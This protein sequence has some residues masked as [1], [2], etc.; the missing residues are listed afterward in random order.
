MHKLSG[1]GHA[2]RTL[3]AASSSINICFDPP[4]QC[5]VEAQHARACPTELIGPLIRVGLGSSIVAF[6][7][8]RLR[9][10]STTKRYRS[11]QAMLPLHFIKHKVRLSVA[12][13]GILWAQGSKYNIQFRRLRRLVVCCHC[14]F[15]FAYM[16]Q[17]YS[18]FSPPVPDSMS[19]L[20]FSSPLLLFVPPFSFLSFP[21]RALVG[22][23]AAHDQ[24]I[25]GQP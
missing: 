8:A 25:L 9:G 6:H 16:S 5:I 13:A 15:A 3:R 11:G 18:S 4:P 1:T 10:S 17:P 7:N 22:V 19:T 20:L 24:P 2:F 23:A 21:Y 14:N 12:Y